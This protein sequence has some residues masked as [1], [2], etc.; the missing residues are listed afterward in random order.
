MRRSRRGVGIDGFNYT[1]TMMVQLGIRLNFAAGS[2]R[3]IK[4]HYAWRILN[5]SVHGLRRRGS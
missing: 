3:N 5:S 4:L 1:N 2:D